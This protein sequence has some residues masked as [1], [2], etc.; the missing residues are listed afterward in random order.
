M[1]DTI[2][3]VMKV[4]RRSRN[5]TTS[6]EA[7]RAVDFV[8]H[9]LATEFAYYDGGFDEDVFYNHIIRG[10]NVDGRPFDE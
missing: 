4:L 7:R 10:S 3:T 2:M 5:T 6:G 8:I 9:E 1:S